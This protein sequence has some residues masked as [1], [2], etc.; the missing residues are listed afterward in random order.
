MAIETI[1]LAVGP[2]DADRAQ[3]LA[4]TLVDLA[5]PTGAN[6]VLAHVFTSSE[7][8]TTLE[9]L[10]VNDH[11]ELTEDEIARR[12]ATIRDIGR[13]LDDADVE[14][15]VRGRVGEHGSSIVA[16]AE[17]VDADFVLVGGRRRSPTGKAVFGSTAQEV[18]LNAPCP[19]TFVRGD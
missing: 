18:I 11:G 8:Q 15:D 7:Y 12:H 3:K 13:S 2:N 6:V 5:V 19:V 10:D 9:S 16:T 17:D 14:Y 1:L 4:E